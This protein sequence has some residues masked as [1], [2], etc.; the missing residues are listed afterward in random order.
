M[1]EQI[2]LHELEVF[3]VVEKF[4]TDAFERAMNTDNCLKSLPSRQHESQTAKKIMAALAHRKLE[5]FEAA[6][7]EVLD[8]QREACQQLSN[9]HKY[10]HGVDSPNRLRFKIQELDMEFAEIN[11][12]AYLF[13]MQFGWTLNG[14]C[15]P[16]TEEFKYEV[17]SLH[18]VFQRK[19]A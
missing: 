9:I 13:A 8:R 12:Q 3:Q 14:K 15:D 17:S 1:I 4:A 10:P 2:E 5:K 18:D 7:T 6:L 11:Q 19:A 16:E